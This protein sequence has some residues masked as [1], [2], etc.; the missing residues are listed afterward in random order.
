MVTDMYRYL[1]LIV[2]MGFGAQSYAGTTYYKWKDASGVTHYGENPPNPETAVKIRV[3][4]KPSGQDRAVEALENARQRQAEPANQAEAD[5]NQRIRERNKAIKEKNCEIQRQNLGQIR[6]NGRIKE[7]DGS[8]ETRY[9]SGAEIDRRRSEIE[10][11]LKE[12]CNEE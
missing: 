1:L 3:S 4:G 2:I 11:Y 8:G 5:V 10:N 7:T 12:N 9:L 6:G